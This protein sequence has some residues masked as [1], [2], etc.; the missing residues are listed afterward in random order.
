MYVRTFFGGTKRPDAATGRE[1]SASRASVA[2][3]SV[4]RTMR[5]GHRCQRTK[6]NL[7]V[8]GNEN[9]NGLMFKYTLLNGG[10]ITTGIVIFTGR[11]SGAL[12]ASF[13]IFVI[14]F[15]SDLIF[16]YD[17]YIYNDFVQFTNLCVLNSALWHTAEKTHD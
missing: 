16:F 12:F 17:C 3:R 8:K 11:S 15:S 1:P 5:A 10:R 2:R 14:F 9:D 6:V 13:L 7:I 4:R